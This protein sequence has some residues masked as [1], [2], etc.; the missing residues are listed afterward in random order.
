L[1]FENGFRPDEISEIHVDDQSGVNRITDKQGRKATLTGARVTV[2]K[3]AATIEIDVTPVSTGKVIGIVVGP[4]GQPVEGAVVAIA[5][6]SRGGV[7]ALTLLRATSDA[8]GSFAVE[9][10]PIATTKTSSAIL[11]VIVTKKGYAGWD[12]EDCDLPASDETPR[13]VGRIRLDKGHSIR[14]RVV[15]SQ[16]EP[17]Q[18]ALVTPRGFAADTQATTTDVN[19]ECVLQDLEKGTQQVYVR[20]GNLSANPKLIVGGPSAEAKI[21][22]KPIPQSPTEQATLP[23]PV[24]PGEL[25]PEFKVIEWSDGGTRKLADFRGKVVVLDF[26]G[27]WCGSCIKAIPKIKELQVK[28]KDQPV[29]FLSIHT[30]GTDMKQVKEMLRQTEWEIPTGLDEGA[31]VDDGT[32]AKRYGVNGYPNFIVVN[33]GGRVNFNIGAFDRETGEKEVERA[34][35]VLSVAW[36]PKAGTPEEEVTERRLRIFAYLYSEAIDRALA[37][38]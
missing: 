15:G 2:A 17:L 1:T 7:I 5:L 31:G 22:L 34:A 12:S 21:F 13:D 24:K 19:G 3:E 29:V 14:L 38:P 11:K 9:G 32:T 20:Y 6:G 16:D 28:Y 35:A 25:A 4:D 26:W 27:T 30:A 23:M 36:P 10:V 33:R 37:V 18:G 8:S